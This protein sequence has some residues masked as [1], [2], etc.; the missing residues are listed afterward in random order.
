RMQN[1]N[2]RRVGVMPR[3]GV[4]KTDGQRSWFISENVR[5]LSDE[6]QYFFHYSTIPG[7]RIGKKSDF[8]TLITNFPMFDITASAA[9]VNQRGS[10]VL[11]ELEWQVRA[12]KQVC[13]VASTQLPIMQIILGEDPLPV[14]ARE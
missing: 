12:K 6:N 11:R 9:Y 7:R 2:L 13:H 10:L 4:Y 1:A 3:V 8:G 14:E 5:D